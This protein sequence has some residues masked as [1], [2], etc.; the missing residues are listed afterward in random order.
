MRNVYN[1]RVGQV[2]KLGVLLDEE[3]SEKLKWIA[4]YMGK[5]IHGVLKQAI[6]VMY[7]KS[8]EA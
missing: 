5:D 3:T 4:D 2:S 1:G 8:I 6:E 7:Y